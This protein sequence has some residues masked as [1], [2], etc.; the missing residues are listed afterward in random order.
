VN[1]GQHLDAAV[2][3]GM[4]IAEKPPLIV[5]LAKL[6]LDTAAVT[7]GSTG[8]TIEFLSAAAAFPT[9]DRREGMQA[10]VERRKPRFQGR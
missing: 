5:S 2:E 4:E 9:E 8:R 6:A 10:F 3:L 1:D 7:D